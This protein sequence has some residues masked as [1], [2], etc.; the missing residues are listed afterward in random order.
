MKNITLSLLQEIVDNKPNNYFAKAVLRLI[1]AEG[2]N[3]SVKR[4]FIDAIPNPKPNLKDKNSEPNSV[5]QKTTKKAKRP[6]LDYRFKYFTMKGFR[7]FPHDK[8]PFGIDFIKNTDAPNANLFLVGNNGSGKTTIFSGLEYLCTGKISA[9]EQRKVEINSGYLNYGKEKSAPFQLS[10]LTNEEELKCGNVEVSSDNF[11]EIQHL[12]RPFFCSENDILEISN[13][14]KDPTN[15]I[16]EQ[17]GLKMSVDLL[18]AL[19]DEKSGAREVINDYNKMKEAN[20]IVKDKDTANLED[21]ISFLTNIAEESFNLWD[22]WEQPSTQPLLPIEHYQLKWNLPTK[23]KNDDKEAIVH[24]LKENINIQIIYLK[25]QQK[26][27]SK[28]LPENCSLLELYSDFISQCETAIRDN[29]LNATPIYLYKTSVD[30]RYNQIQN[31]SFTT[32]EDMRNFYYD[33]YLLAWE[34]YQSKSNKAKSS[35]LI[36]EN[37]KL[38]SLQKELEIHRSRQVESIERLYERYNAHYTYLDSLIKDLEDLINNRIEIFHRIAH[39]F[40][41]NIL[42]DF[43]GMDENFVVELKRPDYKINSLI[44]FTKADKSTETFT[45][46]EFFNSFRFK[47]YCLGLK[48]AIAFSIKTYMNFN[49]PLVMDDVFYSSD[50]TNREKVEEFMRILYEVHDETFKENK[51]NMELQV[52]FLTHDEMLV[53]A[54]AHSVPIY[55]D[56]LYGRLF[57]YRE[58]TSNDERSNN[59]NLFINLYDITPMS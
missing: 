36:Q 8:L 22:K 49:F 2:W 18:H 51:D 29:E 38:S 26:E 41:V 6:F 42:E 59:E 7:K 56:V 10:L 23:S 45:P 9:A 4:K 58:F 28:S 43:M 44:E 17:V 5:S 16:Y 35:F 11:K 52:I 40:V 50:F 33:N 3:A 30:E 32:F 54:A 13:Y 57:D 46:R 20:L 21:K 39:R 25:E 31:L 1:E 48:I 53:N 37:D 19:K 12:I 24:E 15:F 47:I 55:K 27:L 14:S 34:A